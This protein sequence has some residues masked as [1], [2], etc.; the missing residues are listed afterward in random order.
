MKLLMGYKTYITAAISIVLGVLALF[1][2]ELLPALVTHDNAA[3][4]IQTALLAMFIR[5][6]VTAEANK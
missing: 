3:Q 6:G 1:N 5:N 4:F 2:Y